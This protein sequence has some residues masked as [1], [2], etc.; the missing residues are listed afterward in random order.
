MSHP[1]G[2]HPTLGRYIQ[3]AQQQGCDFRSGV[4][5]TDSI[6]RI[7]APDGSKSVV[8]ARMPQSEVLSPSTVAYYDRRLGLDSPFSKTPHG[9]D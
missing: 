4:Y 9:Y 7:V 5:G 3:W 1:F 6:S 8:I 2:G